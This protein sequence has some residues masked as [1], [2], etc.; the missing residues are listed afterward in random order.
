MFVRSNMDKDVKYAKSAGVIT[1][2]ANTVTLVDE[3]IVT[4]AE[5]KACYGDR[6][7]IMSQEYV[8]DIMPQVE[9]AVTGNEEVDNFL[10]GKTDEL[11]EGTEL[12]DEE[13][14]LKLQK[15]AEE[16]AKKAEEERLAAEAKAKEE[17][18]KLEAL[19][20]K[21]AE[22]AAKAK[23][24]TKAPRTLTKKN[25]TKSKGKAGSKNK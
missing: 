24:A 15:E 13:E 2:K 4:A 9:E 8:D 10:N 5:L 23:E 7:S 20:L 3:N 22:E 17:A 16:A 1:I 18:E 12:I 25:S 21:E 11:P 6:I 19:K 14:A